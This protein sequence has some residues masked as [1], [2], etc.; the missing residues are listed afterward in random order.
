L[1]SCH[2]RRKLTEWCTFARLMSIAPR[3]VGTAAVRAILTRAV[4]MCVVT[5][6][7]LLAPAVS[8][9]RGAGNADFRGTWH[10]STNCC[11]FTITSQRASGGCTGTVGAAGFTITGCSVSGNHFSF[12]TVQT[13]SSYRSANSGTITGN[14]LD[15]Q[16]EDSNGNEIPYTATRAG[17]PSG[18]SNGGTPASDEQ[19]V[20][21]GGCSNLQV[22]YDSILNPG[23][24]SVSV[25]AGCDGGSAPRVTTSVN[26]L[27]DGEG[28]SVND[29]LKLTPE[30]LE[31]SGAD[32]LDARV[33]QQIGKDAQNQQQKRYDSAKQIQ[34]QI[35]EIEQDITNGRAPLP[36]KSFKNNPIDEFLRAY[37]S[38]DDAPALAAVDTNLSAEF[39]VDSVNTTR[40]LASN[41]AVQP[42]NPELVLASVASTHP[43]A[44][45]R[46]AFATDIGLATAPVYSRARGLARLTL[47][48]TWVIGRLYVISDLKL[49]PSKLRKAAAVTL[50]SAHANIPAKGSRK[51]T[52]VTST[53]GGR[54]M[55]L[56]EILGLGN[57]VTTQLAL[58]SKVAG[59]TSMVTRQIKIT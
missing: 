21:P 16:F 22:N 25:G 12:T 55:R 36:D 10:V 46:S 57:H 40:D 43:T 2:A 47:S 11:D 33:L 42:P 8:G 50:G 28:C 5:G 15:A 59:K 56:L 39:P 4:P 32:K 3:I 38:P 31:S 24:T 53:L 37:E 45:E 20:C 17:A 23:D 1:P 54:V 14:S 41:S 51:V 27:A 13:S 7:F 9:A 26:R 52:I 29:F 44:A 30:E 19:T 34:D 35:N 49:E 58:T 48:L 18:T 6:A